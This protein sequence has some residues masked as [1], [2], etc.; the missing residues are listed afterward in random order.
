M[1]RL[2]SKACKN[3]FSLTSKEYVSRESIPIVD[4]VELSR[5]SRHRRADIIYKFKHALTLI[6]LTYINIYL[7][8]YESN[9]KVGF[10]CL[11]I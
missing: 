1:R 9:Q 10:K 11:T 8:N 6:L 5:L 3:K 4:L 2:N 7:T